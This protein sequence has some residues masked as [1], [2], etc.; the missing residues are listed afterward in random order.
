MKA[1]GKEGWELMGD[2]HQYLKQGTLSIMECDV[3]CPDTLMHPLLPNKDPVTGKLMFDLRNKYHQWYTS[4]ELNAALAKGY[5]VTRVHK[6]CQ[7][8]QTTTDLFASYMKTFGRLKDEA[9]G[10]P[11]E[12]KTQAQQAEYLQEYKRRTGGVELDATKMSGERNEGMRTVSKFFLNSLWGKLTADSESYSQTTIFR[13][14][15]MENSW[16]LF[17][18]RTHKGG[19]LWTLSSCLGNCLS[20]RWFIAV[21]AV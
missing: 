8:N 3:V 5:N 10:W 2:V 6:V 20:W 7:W 15:Q 11:S 12:V 18:T 4:V 13:E 19:T 17:Y 9:T 1:T 14:N 16:P 21:V